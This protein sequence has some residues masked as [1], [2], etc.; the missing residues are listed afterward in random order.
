[1]AKYEGELFD[2]MPTSSGRGRVNPV[3]PM[4]E[5]TPESLASEE[6]K[7]LIARQEAQMGATPTP[8]A[9][10]AAKEM[11]PV[12]GNIVKEN[13]EQGFNSLTPTQANVAGGIG[14]AGLEYAIYRSLR[15]KINGGATTPT[16]PTTAVEPTLTDSSQNVQTA[17]RPTLDQLRERIT[18]EVPRPVENTSVFTPEDH[19]LQRQQTAISQARQEL[20]GA[21]PIERITPRASFAPSI[22]PSDE[23]HE[24]L[25]S[26]IQDKLKFREQGSVTPTAPV[27]EPVVSVEPTKSVPPPEAPKVTEVPTSPLTTGTGKPAFAGEAPPSEGKQ[28]FKTEYSDISKVPKGYAFIPGGQA[29]DTPRNTLGQET[30]TQEFSKRDFPKDYPEAL[31]VS[32]EINRRLGRPTREEMLAVGIKPPEPTPGITQ[33]IS[34]Y[35]LVKVAGIAGALVALSDIAKAAEKGK[36]P[37]AAAQSI[38]LATDF[39]PGV[40]TAK[41]ALSGMGLNAN[42]EEQLK[43][44]QYRAKVGYGRGMQG[45]TG[46]GQGFRGIAP[47]R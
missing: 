26:L 15:D 1:M 14:A 40:G 37:E 6:G 12:A 45:S 5:V 9:I 21:T 23:V 31:K 27:V 35:K 41:T 29:I 46:G 13:A 39:I 3:I 24:N 36:Y 30:Y 44:L 47:P 38:D 28:R 25:K 22:G 33:K 19:R 18:A 10:A 20:A 2:Q 8:N 16:T 34:G 11:V 32:E 4:D 43:Q 7:K 17:T 42:E